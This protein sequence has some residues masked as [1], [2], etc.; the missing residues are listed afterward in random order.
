MLLSWFGYHKSIARKPIRGSLR[1]IITVILLPLYLLSIILFN[2]DLIY[3]ATVYSAIFCLWSCWE[4]FK[5]IEY[6]ERKGFFALQFRLFN[7]IVYIAL[8]FLY[9]I[10]SSAAIP[11]L[12]VDIKSYFLVA[13]AEVIVLVALATAIILLRVSKSAGK[14]GT[15]TAKIWS[16]VKALLFGTEES[17]TT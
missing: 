17:R 2:K 13:N 11:F 9:L 14:E 7:I 1:F 6:G 15:K 4:Y 12:P 16:E 10:A 5:Y 8:G 3:I